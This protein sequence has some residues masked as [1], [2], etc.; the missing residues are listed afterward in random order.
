MVTQKPG[1]ARNGWAQMNLKPGMF[2]GQL[3]EGAFRRRD[4]GV[5]VRGMSNRGQNLVQR[6]EILCRCKGGRTANLFD[7]ALRE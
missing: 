5:G 3:G 7:V 2:I 6:D 1:G 4:L